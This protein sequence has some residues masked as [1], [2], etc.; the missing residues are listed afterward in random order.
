M[1]EKTSASANATSWLGSSPE[2]GTKVIKNRKKN[3]IP[4]H[5][6]R[7]GGG[8]VPRWL[9]TRTL[10]VGVRAI[11]FNSAQVLTLFYTVVTLVGLY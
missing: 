2:K 5:A 7:E 10:L 6:P 11:F 8:R 4:A 3:L 9:R 1:E